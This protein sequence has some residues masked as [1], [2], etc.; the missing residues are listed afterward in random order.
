MPTPAEH[1]DQAERNEQFATTISNLDPRF[2]EWEITALFYAS[3]HY[4]NALLS[5]LGY[6]AK[7][8]HER[9][10]LIARHTNVSSPYDNLFQHS[11]DARYELIEHT[12]EDVERL[13]SEDFLMVKGEVMSLLGNRP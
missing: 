13:K 8:H 2:T 4:M 5:Y 11:L 10:I 1:L 6:E 7:N 9:R 12:P 3:L